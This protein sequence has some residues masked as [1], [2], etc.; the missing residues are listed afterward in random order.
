MYSKC[1]KNMLLKYA[2]IHSED[3]DNKLINVYDYINDVNN[4]TDE[5]RC[6]N[7]HI[8]EL[9]YTNQNVP[10]FKHQNKEDVNTCPMTRWHLTM[11]APF[12]NTEVEFLKQSDQ[13]HK[14]RRADV[15]L[16]D[17][18]ILEIQNSPISEEEINERD[19]DYTLHNH[20]V[21]WLVNGNNGID[22][23]HLHH[24]NRTY[25]IFR[26]IWK[27]KCFRRYEYIFIDIANK[28]YKICPND[29][30]SNMVDVDEPID[31]NHFIKDIQENNHILHTFIR[32]NQCK[33]YVKQQGAGNGKTFNI[34]QMLASKEFENYRY[35]VIVT[36]Q[37]SAKYQIYNEFQEQIK[38][39]MIQDIEL[40]GT[41]TNENKKYIIKYKNLRTNEEC[42]IVI[43]T[44]DSLMYKLGKTKKSDSNSINKFEENIH[45]IISGCIDKKNINSLAYTD[46]YLELNKEFCIICDET[47]DLPLTY[48]QALVQI[49]RDR[50]V[51]MYIVGDKLQ[52]LA[53][54]ENAF[55]YLIDNDF[56]YIEKISYEPTN[57]IRRTK[58]KGII[59]FV[60]NMV[61]FNAYT[62]PHIVAYEQDDAA[63]NVI[64]FQGKNVFRDKSIIN[65]EIQNIMKLYIDEVETYNRFP[66]SFL[67]VTPFTN[68]N[69]LIN[70]LELAIEQYWQNKYTDKSE[71]KRYAVFHKSQEGTS[72]DLEESKYATR[73]VSIHSAK[74]DGRP[75]VFVIGLDQSSLTRFSGKY[76]NLVYNSLLHV[77]LTRA[78][79]KLYFRLEY[80]GDALSKKLLNHQH[81][82]ELYNIKPSINISKSIK[83]NKITDYFKNNI[84]FKIINDTIISDNNDEILDNESIESTRIVDMS[85]HMIRFAAMTVLFRI[86]VVQKQ[87]HLSRSEV[88]KQF[89]SILLTAKNANLVEASDWKDYNTYFD[90]NCEIQIQNKK[91]GSYKSIYIP[92]VKLSSNKC[93]SDYFD[94]LKQF[95]LDI[96]EKIS[97]ILRNEITYLCPLEQIVLY[98]LFTLC[99]DGLY[100]DITIKD[101]YNIINIYSESFDNTIN[102]HHHCLCK[103]CFSKPINKGRQS[104]SNPMTIY[105]KEHYE[106]M[107]TFERILDEFL[108]SHKSSN[109]LFNH[110]V[111]YKGQNNDYELSNKF[112]DIAYD[113]NNVYCVY[114]IPK[115]SELNYNT[116]VIDT[117][118]NDWIIKHSTNDKFVDKKVHHYILTLNRE[119]LVFDWHTVFENKKSLMT[120]LIK[121]KVIQMFEEEIKILYNYYRHHSSKETINPETM[122]NNILNSLKD[123]KYLPE[124][125][126]DFF[127]D[128]RKRIIKKRTL[129]DQ[130]RKVKQFENQET[131]FEELNSEMKYSINNYFINYQA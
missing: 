21:F 105:L 18:R 20:K 113:E 16:R 101:M 50:Y 2:N 49:M 28:I 65:E 47:Q 126:M 80:N 124:F 62:L 59:D 85:H 9:A 82:N 26:D 13:Q 60:N 68:K 64:I 12:P 125:I 131:F 30:K 92:I 22:V 71:Y 35:F 130:S 73:I 94:I 129:D 98:Y 29:V 46:A 66:N 89:V 15:V 25:F 19:E 127:K 52:S 111:S 3:D 41:P 70:S 5:I 108:D 69:I 31:I 74:G 55:T 40:V 112:K 118:F 43:C 78:K 75:V 48:A 53:Y 77:A 7:N 93:N 79:E 87:R 57:I 38:S 6:C 23:R 76:D 17:N 104:S 106:S 32:P 96:Q 90:K 14:S 116:T 34:I 114:I 4:D 36:K 115:L 33:L 110:P 39:N 121:E 86:K 122:I 88:N 10:Y 24:S 119:L 117:L 123:I 44:I 128:I 83:L 8:L 72:I 81:Q 67:I 102:G 51:D 97:G 54:T 45:S 27:Y 42:Q 11:Q 84:D 95:I 37:H 61:P 58:N 120:K 1:H 99:K 109:F 63:D 107:Q 91:N 103:S 56:S 100:N